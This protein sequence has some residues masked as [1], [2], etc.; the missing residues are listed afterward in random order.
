MG[1]LADSMGLRNLASL[2]VSPRTH[3]MIQRPRVAWNLPISLFCLSHWPA[4]NSDTTHVPSI[5]GWTHASAPHLWST[6][7]S[8][9]SL[10]SYL[11]FGFDHLTRKA[12]SSGWNLWHTKARPHAPSPLSSM[13]DFLLRTLIPCPLLPP[14]LSVCHKVAFD[15][16]LMNAWMWCKAQKPPGLTINFSNIHWILM[17]V[18]DKQ[19]L[20]H[21]LYFSE[22]GSFL[23]LWLQY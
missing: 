13:S 18:G 17:G 21:H 14:S 8:F 19:N 4:S 12:P 6:S 7:L 2:R 22:A 5:L 20:L 10:V 3:I 11:S 23:E 9:T 15:E 1:F 16:Y